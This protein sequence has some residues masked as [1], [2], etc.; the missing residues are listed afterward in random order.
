[1]QNNSLWIILQKMRIP[2]IVII[3]TYTIAIIGLVSIDG[4]D[5]NGELHKMTIFDAL[6]FISYT[7]TTIG[8][9]ETPYS[10]TYS[11]RLWVT[12]SIYLTVIGWF[13]G[14][15]T[16]IGLLQNKLFLNEIARVK[17]KRQVNHIRKKYIIVLGYNYVTNEIIKKLL[18]NDIQV[19]VV[20][21]S[22]E[23][24]NALILENYTPTVPILV[25][26]AH[27][28]NALELAGINKSNCKAVVSLFEDD[29]LNLRIAI[30]S[31][32]L[33][34]NI[35]LAIKATTFNSVNNLKDINT[36]IIANPF[37]VI[38]NEL[39][40]AIKSPNLLKLEKW[41]YQIDT[42]DAH[43]EKL[44]IGKYIICGFGRLG[45][46]IY[47]VLKNES[48]EFVFIELDESKIKGIKEEELAN[49]IIGD[50][51]DKMVLTQAGV[52]TATAIVAFTNNDTVNISILAT[53]KKLN[54]DIITLAREDEIED[55][56]IFTNAQ[57]D[58]LFMPSKILVNKITNALINPLSDIFARTIKKEDEKWAASLVKNLIQKIDS[59]PV[60]FELSIN[61]AQAN[62][63]YDYLESA[64][65]LTLSLFEISLHNRN[66]KNNVIVLLLKREDDIILLPSL[67]TQLKID[68]KLLFACDENAQNDIE[69]IAQNPYE[70]QYVLSG[71]EK[72]LFNKG[73]F[74]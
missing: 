39:K 12:F 2:F 65:E 44:P 17:F 58:Y 49:F 9:G 68:D 30:V 25:S 3:L 8:F 29:A 48:I 4:A 57:I 35:Q 53:A 20:E 33:N 45:K 64:N 18:A 40:M 24:A 5:A 60:L 10:F 46:N 22:E 27:K 56:S 62:Q 74:K 36:N 7:A 1:V 37:S 73:L 66:T 67:D 26:D 15:G 47:K 19:V 52:K 23:K 31:R 54:E 11:Q 72:T 55:L 42:L 63:I 71:K 16:L 13:Y 50:A 28:A 61:P 70:F 32:L 69:Y 14:I 51:D 43:L 41:I 59:N 34:K 21:K 38:A 6:Y